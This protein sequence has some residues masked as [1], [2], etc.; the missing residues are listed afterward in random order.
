VNN[1]VNKG[2]KMTRDETALMPANEYIHRVVKAYPRLGPIVE[3]L[4]PLA[5]DFFLSLAGEN[6]YFPSRSTLQ[7]LA[8]DEYIYRSL[9]GLRSDRQKYAD[10][11]TRLSHLFG[12]HKRHIERLYRHAK[13]NG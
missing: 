9:K 5:G 8:R 6:I 3:L 7:K 2:K 11:V 13:N 1:K 10:E 4:G 12:I